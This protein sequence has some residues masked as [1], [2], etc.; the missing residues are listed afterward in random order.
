MQGSNSQLEIISPDSSLRQ[1]RGADTALFCARLRGQCLLD[2]HRADAGLV[3]DFP[4]AKPPSVEAPSTWV[5]AEQTA[6]GKQS[7]G[8]KRS[9]VKI[10]QV[11]PWSDKS[12]SDSVWR[13]L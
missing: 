5:V 3:P 1:V 4:E 2:S 6:F 10:G 13:L 7:E 8:C 11:L 12:R 9:P